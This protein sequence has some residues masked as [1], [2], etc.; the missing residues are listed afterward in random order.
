[1]RAILAKRW[2]D[3]PASTGSTMLWQLSSRGSTLA[4]NRRPDVSSRSDAVIKAYALGLLRRG[5]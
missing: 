4:I 1:V 3:T 5:V 2:R